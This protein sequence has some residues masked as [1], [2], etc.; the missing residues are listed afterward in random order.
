MI[1]AGDLPEAK[2]A[3]L[4]DALRLARYRR[5]KDKGR[6]MTN[7]LEQ[8]GLTDEINQQVPAG[9][10]HRALWDT[11]ATAHLL[12]VLLAASAQNLS[13]LLKQVS[14]HQLPVDKE[15]PTLWD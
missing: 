6:S 5:P 15:Q 10:P 3:H 7:L 4:I 12:R 9:R 1:S 11:V 2:P 14:P 13:D 8:L